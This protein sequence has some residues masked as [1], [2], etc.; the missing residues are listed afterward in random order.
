MNRDRQIDILLE[1][2]IEQARQAELE[3]EYLLEK[4]HS[5]KKGKFKEHILTPLAMGTLFGALWKGI[6]AGL[7]GENILGG[8]AYGALHGPGIGF[9]G[10]GL[11]DLFD[12]NFETGIL[13]L[14]AGLGYYLFLYNLATGGFSDS[15]SSSSNDDAKLPNPQPPSQPNK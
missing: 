11:G 3:R 8:A 14:L 7:K 12:K 15:N 2:L 5:K 1:R 10:Y 6:V 9:V 13:K 4:L